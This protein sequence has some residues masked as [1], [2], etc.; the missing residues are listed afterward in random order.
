M[1]ISY[2]G[3]SYSRCVRD[4]IEDKIQQEQVLRIISRTSC[5][6]IEDFDLLIEELSSSSYG[7]YRRTF[8]GLDVEKIKFITRNLWYRGA[9]IQ[10]RLLQL[11]DVFS[12][13]P[14]YQHHWQPI[15]PSPKE[16]TDDPI[17]LSTWNDFMTYYA[18]KYPELNKHV[19]MYN[20]DIRKQMK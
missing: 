11:P 2:I 20:N 9:I 13:A 18:L 12:F 4:I 17:L 6:T 16:I 10:P 7:Y 14:S 19:V 3:F 8:N 15:M 1:D 5:L